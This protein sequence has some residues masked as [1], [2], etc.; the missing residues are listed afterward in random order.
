[1]VGGAERAEG[2]GAA[3]I[4]ISFLSALFLVSVSAR[5]QKQRDTAHFRGWGRQGVLS[6]FTL[7]HRWTALSPSTSPTSIHHSQPAQPPAPPPHPPPSTPSP[8]PSP[9]LN[10]ARAS[11]TRCAGAW[12]I[13]WAS[14]SGASAW[15]LQ[16]RRWG[17]RARGRRRRWWR[18]PCSMPRWGG[19]GGEGGKRGKGGK[20]GQRRTGLGGVRGRGVVHWI[21]SSGRKG[22]GG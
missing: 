16:R 18:W 12:P 22:D 3:V 20:G 5:I 13:A 19:E 9:T 15:R 6:G 17:R 14:T 10:R 1:M 4:F 8:T 21:L 2:P 7:E 11:S